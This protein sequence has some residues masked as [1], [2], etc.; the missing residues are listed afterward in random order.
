MLYTLHSQ[1]I[2][3]T[4]PEIYAV[5]AHKADRTDSNSYLSQVLIQ[6]LSSWSHH[7]HTFSDHD[8]DSNSNIS[9]YPQIQTLCA[10]QGEQRKNL[11][12]PAG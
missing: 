9:S 8:S 7:T 12:G 3:G 2:S 4:I 1:A 6:E 11:H 5:C 10:L